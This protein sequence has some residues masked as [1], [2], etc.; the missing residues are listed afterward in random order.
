MRKPDYPIKSEEWLDYG[1]SERVARHL[2]ASPLHVFDAQV[3]SSV[4]AAIGD[5]D[6]PLTSIS[7]EFTMLT[8]GRRG[9]LILVGAEEDWDVEV[10]MTELVQGMLGATEGQ[11]K[12][13]VRAVELYDP[14]AAGVLDLRDGS[15]R[16][17]RLEDEFARHFEGVAPT[18]VESILQPF[19]VYALRDELAIRKC[20]NQDP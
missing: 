15:T 6:D 14:P 16:R 17:A 18:E 1:I 3:S 12:W 7:V 20:M 5:P 2:R 4:P 8:D 10:E 11:P 13:V 9:W 19:E